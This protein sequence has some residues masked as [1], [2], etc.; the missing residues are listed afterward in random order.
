MKKRFLVRSACHLLL[1]KEGRILLSLREN[2]GF[3]DGSYGVVAGHLDGG[4]AAMEAM[5]REAKEE[6]SIDIDRKNLSFALVMHRLSNDAEY[7]DF[8]YS[9]ETWEGEVINAEPHKCGGLKFYGMD[10]LPENMI[11]YVRRA[12]RGYREGERYIEFG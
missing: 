3:A 2:T 10:E 11:P 6:A 4:E 1:R 7:I 5:A 9:C 8:F 12:I